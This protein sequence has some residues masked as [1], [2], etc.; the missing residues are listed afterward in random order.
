[1]EIGRQAI[2]RGG[3]I[4]DAIRR[5][6]L[7]SPD[8]VAFSGSDGSSMT[9]GELPDAVETIARELARREI[10]PGERIALM[11]GRSRHALSALFAAWAAGAS[12]VLLDERHP[13]PRLRHIVDDARCRILVSSDPGAAELGL[14]VIDLDTVDAP[15]AES[16]RA[17]AWTSRL[18]D[19]EAY[20]VYTSGTTGRPKGVRVSTANVENFLTV[21]ST[22]RYQAGS[23]A[24]AVVSP[25]FDGWLWSVLTPF[26]H[27]A[28]CVTLDSRAGPLAPQ[29][30]AYG[31]TNLS[32]TPTL[33]ASLNDFPELEVAVVAG[34]RC[35]E[36]LVAR[37]RSASARLINVYGPT[38]TTIAATMADT[39]RGDDPAAIGR[40]LHGY[41]VEVVDEALRP[42]PA[43]VEGEILIGGDGVSLG[44]VDSER[45]QPSPFVVRDGERLYRSGDI[46]V[47]RADGQLE[48]RGRL[49]DQVKVG[50]F[51]LEYAEVEALARKTPGVRDAVAY[52]RGVPPTVAVAVV[53]DTE[54]ADRDE[55]SAGLRGVFS[56]NLPLQLRP[57]M[58]RFIA[59]VPVDP[60]T[61]KIARRQVADLADPGITPS[62]GSDV[63]AHVH[64]A[65]RSAFGRV[66]DDDAD[67]Y[68]LGGHSLLA[69]QLANEIGDRVGMPVTVSDILLQPT[70]AKQVAVIAGRR[71]P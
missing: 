26:V 25:A 63:R 4:A 18:P 12:A 8:A 39:W 64:D 41:R 47:L 32:M 42:L 57:T 19:D 14:A 43:G 54:N 3:L 23:V 52:L 58:I 28:T 49:D 55:I 33:Y 16:Q 17:F 2:P 9:F 68:A 6:S 37:L 71:R 10:R 36:S 61:G 70:P 51:R 44:Y 5:W 48:C 60:S 15:T 20:V 38:E 29:I 7:A 22:L 65:W 67:F 56:E 24:A 21:A 35:P 53:A 27:G 1:M 40:P 50:G 31:V 62:D 13:L 34:E 30:A 69:A 66:V 45:H 11:A 59:A 46:G